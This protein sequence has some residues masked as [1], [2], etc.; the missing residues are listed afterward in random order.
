MLETTQQGMARA[1]F[2]KSIAAK[3]WRS[4]N[5]PANRAPNGSAGRTPSPRRA[6]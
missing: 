3:H 4:E 2:G 5:P 6:A 1:Q